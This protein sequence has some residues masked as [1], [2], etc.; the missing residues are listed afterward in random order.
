MPRSLVRRASNDSNRRRHRCY[1]ICSHSACW[2]RSWYSD[3]IVVFALVLE[4]RF[5]SLVLFLKIK[6]FAT[7]LFA[8]AILIFELRR[9]F[10]ELG[11]APASCTHEEEERH[12]STPEAW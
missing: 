9:Q 4:L 1:S 8:L 2:P 7:L 5:E 11:Q 10:Q 12:S 3:V 6:L